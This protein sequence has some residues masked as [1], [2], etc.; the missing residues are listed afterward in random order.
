[1]T[2]DF[3]NEEQRKKWQARCPLIPLRKGLKMSQAELAAAIG[4]VQQSVSLFEK[5]TAYPTAAHMGRLQGLG[6]KEKTYLDWYNEPRG[7]DEK[8]KKYRESDYEKA[9]R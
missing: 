7:G 5:G 9:I 4:A 6:L 8:R 1:M 3:T 2:T